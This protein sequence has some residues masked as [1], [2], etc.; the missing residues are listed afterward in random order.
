MQ[1]SK[2]LDI[3]YTYYTI[4]E[5]NNIFSKHNNLDMAE[6]YVDDDLIKL[7][8]GYQNSSLIIK[9]IN[10]FKDINAF[11]IADP[12]YSLAG[13]VVIAMLSMKKHYRVTYKVMDYMLKLGANMSTLCR[14]PNN[15]IIYDINHSNYNNYEN[16]A[17]MKYVANYFPI[18][19][20]VRTIINNYDILLFDIINDLQ[21]IEL[22]LLISK[23]K[24]KNLPKFIIT[25]KI[26][27][28]YLLFK[29]CT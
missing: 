22:I 5:L 20:N 15:S 21:F 14:I 4:E 2:Y 25:H 11:E 16:H 1:L 19:Q 23:C 24:H 10:M 13:N 27:Y 28:Y 3:K 26:L 9:F 18:I 6:F 12:S 17:V 7:L 8:Y 29:N